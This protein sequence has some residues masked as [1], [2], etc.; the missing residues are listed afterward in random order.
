MKKWV[1]I[2]EYTVYRRVWGIAFMTCGEKEEVGSKVV[3]ISAIS[4][5]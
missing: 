4:V 3:V 2:L 1:I 5:R